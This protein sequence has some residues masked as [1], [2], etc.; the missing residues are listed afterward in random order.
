MSD[1][2]K[3]H[4]LVQPDPNVARAI[5]K[6]DVPADQKN[7]FKAQRSDRPDEEPTIEMTEAELAEARA[8]SLRS[9]WRP[10]SAG[11]ASRGV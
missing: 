3:A 5:S 4:G 8:K 10:V 2:N 6:N 7:T 9:Q 11:L 1:N